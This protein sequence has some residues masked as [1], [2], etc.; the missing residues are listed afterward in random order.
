MQSLHKVVSQIKEDINYHYNMLQKHP[1]QSA[2]WNFHL[3]WLDALTSYRWKL[4]QVQM[5]YKENI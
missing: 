3:G 2:D 1:E 5:F 4:E